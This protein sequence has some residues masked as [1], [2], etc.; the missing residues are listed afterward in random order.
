VTLFVLS[1]TEG[2]AVKAVWNAM[3]VKRKLVL[4]PPPKII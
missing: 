1:A 4:A 2:I 3:Q